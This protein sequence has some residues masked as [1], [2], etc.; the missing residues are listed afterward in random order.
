M[1]SIIVRSQKSCRPTITFPMGKCFSTLALSISKAVGPC[2]YK[3]NRIKSFLPLV[4]KDS[5]EYT[6]TLRG[7]LFFFF[8]GC[9]VGCLVGRLL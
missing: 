5:R 2:R 7:M 8:F 9:L 3:L 4:L 1:F 6:I